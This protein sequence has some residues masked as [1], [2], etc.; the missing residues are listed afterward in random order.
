[1]L[2]LTRKPKERV[3]FPNLGISIEIVR[4]DGKAVRVGIDAPPEVRV[5][6]G[7]LADRAEIPE[8]AFT[9]GS[10]Q[11]RFRNRLNAGSLA[12]HVL[13]RQLDAGRLDEAETTLHEALSAFADLDRMA[14]ESASRQEPRA[15]GRRILVVEDNPHERELLAAYLRLCGYEVDAVEDG[16]AALEYLTGHSPPDAALI[17]MQMPRMNGIDTV[18]AIRS[19]PE[20]R[21][22]KLCAV[23]GADPL[24]ARLPRGD[25]GI[26]RW[27]SKPLKP[28]E[29]AHEL[30]AELACEGSFAGE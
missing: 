28:T 25:R 14:T 6:R 21:R 29:F 26:D 12:L 11:H 27:F 20:Y 4:V 2:V 19:K 15:A 16:V 8:P 18:A 24:K 7:E 10:D 22:I 30:E 5:L 9:S 23:S 13:Q 3:L 1:M 17:D